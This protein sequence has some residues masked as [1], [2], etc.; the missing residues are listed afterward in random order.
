MVVDN[1]GNQ[2]V[3][4]SA[5]GASS[6][7]NVGCVAVGLD[8]HVTSYWSSPTTYL[9]SFGSSQQITL[10]GAY[11]PSMGRLYVTCYMNTGGRVNTIQYNPG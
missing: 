10:T 1:A 11:V 6:A 8:Y 7:N 4:V 2:T 3:N 9:P 5:Y